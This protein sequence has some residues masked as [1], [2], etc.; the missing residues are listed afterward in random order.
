M[1]LKQPVKS[2]ATPSTSTASSNTIVTE[3][4]L[5]KPHAPLVGFK[6]ILVAV[7]FS[8]AS[9][10]A[11]DH[12]LALAEPFHSTIILLHIVEPAVHAQNYMAVGVALDESNQNL[13]EA[14]RERLAELYRKRVGQHVR[15]ESLVRMGRAPSEISD[16]ARALAADLIVLGAHGHGLPRQGNLGSTA[17]HVVR[18]ASC[19][20]LVVTRS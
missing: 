9:S 10:R 3:P 12:A 6:R 7:D 4:V 17:D 11:L 15:A 14:G 1:R 13:I 19:P 5:C 8:D 20:V 16:T 18:Q 2:E